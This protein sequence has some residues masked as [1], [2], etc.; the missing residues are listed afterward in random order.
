LQE[1]EKRVDGLNN[2]I[3]SIFADNDKLWGFEINGKDLV[4]DG[5]YK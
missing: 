2:A 5:Q 4:K 1:I 3:E